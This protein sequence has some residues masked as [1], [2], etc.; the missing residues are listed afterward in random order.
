MQIIT[1]AFDGSAV[2]PDDPLIRNVVA[3]NVA[4]FPD[5]WG[6]SNVDGTFMDKYA[7]GERQ[8]VGE[9]SRVVEHTI[10]VSVD[11]AQD[12]VRRVLELFRGLVRVPRA[13]RDV[14][15]AVHVEIHVDGTLHQG[16]SG[17]TLQDI[18]IG[19]R[20]GMWGELSFFHAVNRHGGGKEKG[21]Q[22]EAG[23]YG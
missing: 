14:E 1:T 12:P 16:R 20:K 10:A 2:E 23:R 7:F 18:T 11:Q 22:Y 5:V 3:I 19:K 17:N 15:G 6:S 8:A 21:L 13:I 9:D 4:Q